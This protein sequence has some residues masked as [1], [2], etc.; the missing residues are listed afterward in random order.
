[1]KSSIINAIAYVADMKKRLAEEEALKK[2][3]LAE[4]E[5]LKKKRLAEEDS[6]SE[7]SKE[8]FSRLVFI[9]D[10]I[11]NDLP[12]VLKHYSKEVIR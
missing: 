10:G 3:R 1:M 6:E 9:E 7:V 11:L 12:S 4:E 2:K 8:D 5:A